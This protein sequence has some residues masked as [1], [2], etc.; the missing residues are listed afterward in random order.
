MQVRN[1]TGN[2]LQNAFLVSTYNNGTG[3]LIYE[4]L[5]DGRGGLWATITLPPTSICRTDGAGIATACT[6]TLCLQYMLLLTDCHGPRP[7]CPLFAVRYINRY[8]GDLS[9][10][11]AGI[12]DTMA[13]NICGNVVIVGSMPV[14]NPA[15]GARPLQ[16]SLSEHKHR[17]VTCSASLQFSHCYSM[18]WKRPIG[19]KAQVLI[20]LALWCGQRDAVKARI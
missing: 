12:G 11:G 4:C 15:T 13:L 6:I 19:L 9:H 20:A 3:N 10:P 8:P 2:V 1:T 7:G 5:L 18:F 16:S 17:P 14:E